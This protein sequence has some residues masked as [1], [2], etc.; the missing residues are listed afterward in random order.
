MTI[1]LTDG[2]AGGW[3]V[4]AADFSST[5]SSG[6]GNAAYATA[7]IKLGAAGYISAKNF[8]ID[9]AGNAKFRGALEGATGTFSG[10]ISVAAFNSGYTGSSAAT[11]TAAVA[12]NAAAAASTASD[13]YGQANTATSNASSAYGQ[14][15][16]ATS[17]AASAYGQANTATSNAASAYGQANTATSNA[18]AAHSTANSKVTHASVNTSST[19]VGGGVGGWGI[20][21]YHLAG[22]AQASSSTRNFAI[23]TSG[24][25]NATFLANGGIVMGSDG[26][27]SAKQFYIDTSGNAKFKG[28]LEGDDVTVNGQLTLPSSGANVAG[29]TVGSWSTNTMDNKHIVSVGTGA[30]FYQGFV[31]LTGGTSYVKTISIQ[32]RTGSSTAS[33]GTLIYE[34][35]RIDYYTAGNVTEGRLYSTAQTANMPIAFTYTGSGNVSLFVR[36]QADTGPDTLGSAEA[37][38]IKFG[39]TDPLFSFANQSGVAVSTAFYSNTQVVGGFA[40][41][42]TVSI[43]NTSYTRYK[44]DGG[45]FG[46]ANSNIANG[47]YINV[48]ITS[49]S[50]NSTTRSSTVT[51]GESSAGFS[52]TTTGGTPPGGGGGGGGCFVEGTPVVMADGSLKAIETVTAGESVKSFSHSSLS[53]E[54]DA[55]ITWTT[56]EIGTGTFGTSTVERVTD[57]HAHDNYYWINYNLKV[58]NEHPMLAFKDAVFKFVR[59]EDLAVGDHLVLED[60]SREEIFAIPNVR[61]ACV[62]HN[63]DVEDQDTYVVK[64]GNGNGYIAHNVILNEEKL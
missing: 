7:G 49:A 48:E 32:A 33:E 42:K 62:T 28:T 25:G 1:T 37:R 56:P 17:N 13:A 18:A 63:M 46:T 22:G 20:T 41:T 44:I 57:A 43:S 59:A 55:W 10:S 30:G 50:T 47:S 27:V 21:T 36:A 58:T 39:T 34:T 12:A 2:S 45:S 31:R 51:I 9:T 26:F 8:Y 64:G 61:V 23:G 3:N 4:N 35:P 11:A 53:L 60:G 40:G 5:N 54:E 19:I 14:A 15:N 6:G 16:T 38:F 29:S 24:S 52:I